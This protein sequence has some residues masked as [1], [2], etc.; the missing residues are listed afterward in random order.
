MVIDRESLRLLQM[1]ASETLRTQISMVRRA[2]AML[3]ARECT[4]LELKS[5]SDQ[6]GAIARGAA[7]LMAEARKQFDADALNA[8]K[9]SPTQRVDLLIEWLPDCPIQERTRL[10]V[11]LAELGT[12][13]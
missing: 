4:A 13:L 9:L 10:A 6:C 1:Q 8:K 2:Q 3:E 11:A 7:A 12:E 5:L